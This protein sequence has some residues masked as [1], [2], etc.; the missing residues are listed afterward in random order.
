MDADFREILES[1]AYT[2]NGDTELMKEFDIL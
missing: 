2:L 1:G